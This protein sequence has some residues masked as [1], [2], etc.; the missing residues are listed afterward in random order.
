MRLKY[1]NIPFTLALIFGAFVPF[2]TVVAQDEVPD[3]LIFLDLETKEL[4]LTVGDRSK[5]EYKFV[6]DEGNEYDRDIIFWMGVPGSTI[7]GVPTDRLTV[8]DQGNVQALAPGEYMVR[9]VSFN[10]SKDGNYIN[11]N[12][13]PLPVTTIVFKEGPE[14]YYANS[15][16]TLSATPMDREGNIREDA[17]VV[18]TSSDNGIATVSKSGRLFLKKKGTVQITASSEG[19]ATSKK[20]TV[21]ENPVTEIQL[22]A[23]EASVRTGDVVHLTTSLKDKNGKA[24]TGVPV[25]Y[26]FTGESDEKEG[27]SGLGLIEQNGRFVANKPGF[28]TIIAKS[29]NISSEVHVE[30]SPRNVRRSISVAGHGSIKV[31]MAD[32]WLWEGVDGRDYAITGTHSANGE[33]YFWDVTDPSEMHIIDTVTVDARTVNDVKISEDGTIGV[34]SRE[35]ASNRRN[36]IVIMDVKDPGNVKILS[37]FD[38]GLTGGVHNVFIYEDH[39]YATNNV[40]KYDIINIEDPTKPYRVSRFEL[41]RPGHVVHDVW[42]EDGIAYSSNFGD[43][44]AI[45]DVGSNNSEL[46]EAGGSPENPVQLASFK[47]DKGWNHAAFPFKSKSTGDFYVVAGDEAF[48]VGLDPNQAV[49]PTGWIHFVKFNG[50]EKAEEV[51]RYEVPEAGSHNMWVKDDVMYVGYYNGGLRVVDISGELMGN[52]YDQGR[53]IASFTPVDPDAWTP[54]STMTWGAMPFKDYIYISD[55]N[56]G[57]WA[58]ELGP[59]PNGTH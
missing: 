29:G 31:M 6:D 25:T 28:F 40:K 38:D 15:S 44:L 36:G 27:T 43:G 16:Y 7:G 58:F 32:F 26:S 54:N 3:S 51:A 11:I 49:Q 39:I 45:V 19:V 10:R 22:E 17:P 52:L 57:L 33:A 35:G 9:A 50:W 18:F 37:T 41:D 30:A 21:K 13:A 23:S 34:L 42:V 4:N 24:V 59:D 1:L 55:A 12:I 46:G 8:D 53:E 56:S 48:K 14:T 47:F 2:E 20:I 5:I